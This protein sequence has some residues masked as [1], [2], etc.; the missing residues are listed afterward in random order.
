MWTEQFPIQYRGIIWYGI[1]AISRPARG[2][3][4]GREMSNKEVWKV[5]AC[6]RYLRA[7]DRLHD[8]RFALDDAGEFFS[9]NG[10]TYHILER[11]MPTVAYRRLAVDVDLWPLLDG[12]D[13]RADEGT[14]GP[15]YCYGKT[16]GNLTGL[17][18]TCQITE[19]DAP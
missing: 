5:E 8:E 13:L 16:L 12:Y 3:L 6:D 10:H 1:A 2:K 15:I 14:N 17:V 19:T 7:S 9:K 11:H 4:P 18:M